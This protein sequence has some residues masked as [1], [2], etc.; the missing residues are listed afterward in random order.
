M[1]RVTIKG[2]NASPAPDVKIVLNAGSGPARPNDLHPLFD[3]QTWRQTRLDIDP[4]FNPDVV[5]SIV[6]MRAVV[7]DRSVDAIWCSHNIEHLRNFEV[8][9]ALRE[10][11]RVLRL[12]GFLFVTCPDLEA[13]VMLVQ[14]KGID[15]FAYHS[16]AGPIHAVDMLFGH[17]PSI[18]AGHESM[19][20]R[21]GFTLDRLGRMLN[22]A[23]FANVCVTK[24]AGYDLW[25]LAVMPKT[26][27]NLLAE[28]LE[29]TPQ[30]GLLREMAGAISSAAS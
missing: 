5:A 12:D 19:S 27:L 18:E 14:D 20:H 25:A 8:M 1:S 2:R 23:G 15:A 11:R 24:G 13:V 30:N 22:E 7:P 9:P 3:R 16:P 21:T 17:S 26:D 10:F 28:G 6:D 29:K 4:T